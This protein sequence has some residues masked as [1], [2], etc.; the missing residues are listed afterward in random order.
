MPVFKPADLN[1]F[2]TPAD[3]RKWLDQNHEGA[4]ALWL[5]F[6]QK[7]SGRPSITY[8]EALDEALCYGWIDGV[9]KAIDDASYTIRFTPRKPGS[10]WSQINLRRVGELTKIG[11]MMPS[12]IA[13]FRARD[14]EKEN[15]YSF[16]NRP[17][18]LD[19]IGEKKFRANKKAWE[20]FQSQPPGYQ[21]VAIWWVISAKR[22]ETRLRRL[23]K[24]IACAEKRERIP[25]VISKNRK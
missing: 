12:G 25:Q 8:P 19:P 1:F 6:F 7:D 10:I 3:F 5:A 22:E 13:V 4:T 24:L 2:K 11:R 9:R 17:Q 23:Q 18:K 15:R 16:E 20:F 21:R 14:L